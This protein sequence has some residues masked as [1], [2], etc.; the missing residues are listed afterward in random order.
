MQR[1]DLSTILL[2]I[3]FNMLNRTIIQSHSYQYTYIC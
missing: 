2:L 3:M 1:Y